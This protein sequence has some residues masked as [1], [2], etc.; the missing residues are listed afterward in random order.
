MTSRAPL[1]SLDELCERTEISD[2]TRTPSEAFCYIDI[3]SVSNESFAIREARKLLGKDAPSRAKKRIR[4]NDVILATTR[5]YLKSIAIVPAD[6]DQC[7]CSTGFCVLRAKA[8]VLPEWIYYCVQAQ[9]FMEQL[10]PK[11]RGASYPAVTDGD[12]RECKIPKPKADEQRRLVVRIK[13]CF[14]RVD[15]MRLLREEAISETP[16]VEERFLADLETSLVGSAVPL[17][18]LL[19][20]T[21]N[22]KSLQNKEKTHN[23]RALT[24]SAVRT[25]KLDLHA[26]KPVQIN[27][28][29][30]SKYLLKSGDV[31]I[32]RSN[33]RELV[34]LS[35]IAPDHID[36]PTIFSDLLIRLTPKPNAI[37]P[38]YLTI[39][40]RMPGV[41]HQ[42]RANA[43][44]SSQTMVK[45]SGERLRT[46]EVPCPSPEEQE[47]IEAKYTEVASVTSAISAELDEQTKDL[48]AFRE[49]VL[50]E[51]F[52][53]NL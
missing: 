49:A 1:V 13:E 6:F 47:R 12:V 52:A 39:A 4:K 40:L 32:S 15:E 18:E 14:D 46:V 43:I 44:G 3:S 7:I 38:L 53:G 35:A 10:L 31:L 22:G 20:E 17:R 19:T 27:P 50:R 5:P 24:L 37:R 21:Q 29:R 16:L 36:E 11:M 23:G 8:G 28:G 41:R 48:N 42:L 26:S 2:P 33:T 51:A 9:P 34:A 25:H 30:D 45:I